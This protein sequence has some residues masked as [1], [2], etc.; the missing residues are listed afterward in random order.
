MIYR[1]K[2]RE[3]KL[4][5]STFKNIRILSKKTAMMHSTVSL[6]ACLLVVLS[7]HLVAGQPSPTERLNEQRRQQQQAAYRAQQDARRVSTRRLPAPCVV[8]D[9]YYPLRTCKVSSNP[10]EC[11]RG[12]NAWSNFVECCRPGQG[13]AFPQGCTDFNKP[14]Q[15]WVPGAFYPERNCQ[16]T[17]NITR[18]SYNWGQWAS[19]DEC[20]APGRA[21]VDGCSL[22]EPCWVGTEWFP[23][24]KCSTTDDR[25][26][27]TRGWGTYTSEVQ[28]CASGGAFSDGCGISQDV[29]MVQVMGM[30]DGDFGA[31]ANAVPIA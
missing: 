22:P 19:E 23:T 17:T 7:S 27:C 31:V 14:V 24:R 18:C 6:V 20:C 11:G 1:T 26:I 4:P 13:G 8:P 5:T 21:F 3:L 16:A 25:S 12:F 15:C 28:C 2:I 10:Q 29:E 30:P 9:S